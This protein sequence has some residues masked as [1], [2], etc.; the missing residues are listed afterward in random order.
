MLK[1]LPPS[2]KPTTAGEAAHYGVSQYLVQCQLLGISLLREG[3][4]PHLLLSSY[5]AIKKRLVPQ[6]G[7]Y[8]LP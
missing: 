8:C 6:R 2:G 4:I 1:A 5:I 3:A 7:E